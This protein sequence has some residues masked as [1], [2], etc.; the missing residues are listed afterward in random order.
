MHTLIAFAKEPLPGRVKTRLAAAVGPRAATRLY[1]AFAGDLARTW[2]GLADVH[3]AWWVDGDDRWLRDLAGPEASFHVQPAGDLGVRLEQA[4]RA[5]FDRGGGPVAVA[6]TDCPLLAAGRIGALFAAVEADADAALIPAAD[7]G[8]VALALGSPTPE[9]FR[10]IP[11]STN[12]TGSATRDALQRAG[13]RVRLL[14][15]LYDVD[16]RA[17][18]VRLAADLARDPAAAPETARVAAEVLAATPA[19]EPDRTPALDA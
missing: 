10:G 7:G 9:A 13:R 11:W 15:P 16:T 6:G 18:L 1:R 19:A 8:Y 14:P 4:F 12:R 2:R 3:V 17:D 5:T